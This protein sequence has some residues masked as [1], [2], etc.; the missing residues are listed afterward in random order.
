MER[1]T[2]QEE[3]EM[4]IIKTILSRLFSRRQPAYKYFA[5]HAAERMHLNSWNQ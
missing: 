4:T 1:G 5:K 2:R 3:D